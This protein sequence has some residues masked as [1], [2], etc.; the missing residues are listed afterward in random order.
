MEA[1]K[2]MCAVCF[3]VLVATLTRCSSKDILAAFHQAEPLSSVGC[4]VFVT[5]TTGAEHE[6]RGCIGTFSDSMKI[7]E[8]V[9]K[10]ALISALEDSRFP[11]ISAHELPELHVSVSLLVNFTQ[12]ATLHDWEIGRHGV[13]L[14]VRRGTKRFASTFL[15]EVASEQGWDKETTL[16]YLLRKAGLSKLKEEDEVEFTTYESSKC[17][18]SYEEHRA[19]S[20]T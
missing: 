3:D 17:T 8:V 19:L 5:W 20:P 9:P 15:P 14:E 7:G 6:L 13:Q 18:L 2:L 10:Y 12:R 16:A 4:P 1:T 11:P